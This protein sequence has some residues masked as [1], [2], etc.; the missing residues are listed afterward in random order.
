MTLPPRQQFGRRS[1]AA[2]PSPASAF[3]RSLVSRLDAV[4]GGEPR[5]PGRGYWT[6]PIGFKPLLAA[7]AALL[8]LEFALWGITDGDVALAR[9]PAILWPSIV[10]GL[11]LNLGLF[12]AIYAFGA[13]AA[14]RWMRWTSPIAFALAGAGS[15]WTWLALVCLAGGRA[16]LAASAISLFGG[17]LCGFVYRQIAGVEWVETAAPA[18]E[19]SS[20]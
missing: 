16:S 7:T 9:A 20:D 11:A 14:V 10:V 19:T 4:M 3:A 2:T 18:N 15:G 13:L 12:A 1:D 5:V 17:A 6:A 8:A